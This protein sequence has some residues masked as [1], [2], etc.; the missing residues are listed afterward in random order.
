MPWLIIDVGTIEL[1]YLVAA[2]KAPV[3]CLQLKI[4]LDYNFYMDNT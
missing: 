2:M 4:L 3:A 1:A